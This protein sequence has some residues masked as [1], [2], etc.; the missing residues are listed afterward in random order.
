LPLSDL[1]RK[2]PAESTEQHRQ[3]RTWHWAEHCQGSDRHQTSTGF[4][5]ASCVSRTV[6]NGHD[7]GGT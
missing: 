5:V 6:T 4:S 3:G 7:A 1:V 2:P